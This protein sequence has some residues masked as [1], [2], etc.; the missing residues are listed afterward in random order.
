M[1]TV[2]GKHAVM[3]PTMNLLA[4]QIVQARRIVDVAQTHLRSLLL[5]AA[6]ERDGDGCHYCTV[7]TVVNPSAGS[8]HR[9][10]TL[11]HVVPLSAGGKDELE[12]VVCCCRSCNARKGTRPQRQYVVRR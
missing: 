11:D 9:E 8:Y 12:N 2:E 5:A 1:G 10:R 7:P 6:V 3:A 4:A